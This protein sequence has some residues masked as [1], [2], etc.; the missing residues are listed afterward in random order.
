MKENTQTNLH[1]EEIDC[2]HVYMVQGNVAYEMPKIDEKIEPEFTFNEEVKPEVIVE[3]SE[4]KKEVVEQPIKSKRQKKDVGGS[5]IKIDLDNIVLSPHFE[6]QTTGS[7][8]VEPA[9]NNLGKSFIEFA[10]EQSKEVRQELK[11]LLRD[12]VIET[13]CK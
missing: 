11:R 13:K 1:S 3:K 5:S 12:K 10:N 8:K 6:D 2:R 9:K 7:V 4:S